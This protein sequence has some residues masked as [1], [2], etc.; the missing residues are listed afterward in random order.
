MIFPRH[1]I[2]VGLGIIA[3]IY[4]VVRLIGLPGL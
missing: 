4:G 2:I 1:A 3:L